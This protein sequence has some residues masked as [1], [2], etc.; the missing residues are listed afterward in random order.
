MEKIQAKFIA[1]GVVQGVG[2]RYFVYSRASELNLAG[3]AKNLYD[4]SVEIIAEGEKDKVELLREHILR[5]PS[6]SRVDSCD[7]EYS[8]YKGEYDRFGVA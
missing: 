3:Y 4:G 1:K 2:F 5:G 8:E 7:A 6:R